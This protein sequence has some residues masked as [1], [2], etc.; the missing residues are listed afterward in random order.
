MVIDGIITSAVVAVVDDDGDD[1][2]MSSSAPA[3]S[4]AVAAVEA[5]DDGADRSNANRKTNVRR[6]GSGTCSI[7]EAC[8]GADDGVTR[9]ASIDTRPLPLL[10]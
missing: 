1:A 4:S 8:C 6:T 9:P 3:P 2:L 10:L 5:A 7:A